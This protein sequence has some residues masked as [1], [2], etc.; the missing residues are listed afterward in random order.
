MDKKK[1]E[2]AKKIDFSL[3]HIRGSIKSIMDG[4]HVFSVVDRHQNV[5][6]REQLH[7]ILIEADAKVLEILN[8]QKSE[9]EKEL[10]EL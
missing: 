3:G 5:I 4:Y 8:E 10:A 1:F 6:D 7:D 2:K 9:L